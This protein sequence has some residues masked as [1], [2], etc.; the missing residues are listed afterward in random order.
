[1]LLMPWTRPDTLQGTKHGLPDIVTQTM[2]LQAIVEIRN[3]KSKVCAK[4]IE[5]FVSH[6]MSE[7]LKFLLPMES[8]KV[9][10][11]TVLF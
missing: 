9:V 10:T 6:I 2:M 7:R 4:M 11:S 3:E 1:M 5:R 8:E